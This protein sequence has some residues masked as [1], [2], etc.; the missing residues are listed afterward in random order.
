MS[1]PI[2]VSATPPISTAPFGANLEL[3]RA[4]SGKTVFSRAFAKRNVA[5]R[6]LS[7][8]YLWKLSGTTFASAF[9]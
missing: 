8:R 2:A 9:G 3:A 5:G 7:W 1:L 4:S 6:R